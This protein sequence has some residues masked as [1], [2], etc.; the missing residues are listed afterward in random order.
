MFQSLAQ[1]SY[2]SIGAQR[3]LTVYDSTCKT[4]GHCI[5]VSFIFKR[6][7]YARVVVYLKIYMIETT[8]FI[9][10]SIQ[11]TNFVSFP[12]SIEQCTCVD[13][14]NMVSLFTSVLH[15]YMKKKHIGKMT[16]PI[17]CEAIKLENMTYYSSIWGEVKACRGFCS[18]FITGEKVSPF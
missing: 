13:S 14:I 1:W 8:I 12:L 17:Y 11:A 5:L 7:I 18:F 10:L 9:V 3:V 15:N 16:F 4:L 2:K 6:R